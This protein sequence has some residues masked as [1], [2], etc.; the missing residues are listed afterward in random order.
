MGQVLAAFPSWLGYHHVTPK[1]LRIWAYP[2]SFDLVILESAFRY[3]QVVV[4]WH[5]KMQRDARTLCRLSDYNNEKY[6]ADHPEK[7]QHNAL[8]DCIAQI[9]GVQ[10]SVFTFGTG[11]A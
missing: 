8:E 5:Y 3:E 4:P 9:H 7:R 6:W 2:P 11:L 1:D 10:F